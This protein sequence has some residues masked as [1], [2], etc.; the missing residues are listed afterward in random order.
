MNFK[1][2]RPNIRRFSEENQTPSA[3]YLR[4]VD[5]AQQPECWI[6]LCV[7]EQQTMRSTSQSLSVD[8]FLTAVLS[9]CDVIFELKN[10]IPSLVCS[11]NKKFLAL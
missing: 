2:K 10:D 5:W 7:E 9:R 6:W 11:D 3:P 8:F 4:Y 1:K